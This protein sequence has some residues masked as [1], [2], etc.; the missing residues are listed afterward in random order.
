MVVETLGR[1][2]FN[3][4][5]LSF[6]QASLSSGRLT[7]SYNGNSFSSMLRQV[8]ALLARLRAG[9]GERKRVMLSIGGWQHLPTFEAIRSFGVQGFVRQ[10]SEE[11]IVPLGLDGIDL[12]LEPQTGGLDHW[13]RAHEEYGLTVVELTNEYKR[14]RPEHL[15]THAPISG[16]AAQIYTQPRPLPGLP[17]GLLAATR[18]GYGNNIDWLNVQMYEGGQVVGGDIAGYY[19]AALAA[20]LTKI[21]AQTGVAATLGF[22]TPLFQPDAK[23]PLAFCREVITSINRRCAD[24]D[25]GSVT[26]VA[27]WD[28]RQVAPSMREWSDG[29]NSVLHA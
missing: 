24:L 10:L 9:F 16:V 1:S 22:L 7:L 6:L 28:Y 11:V 13:I 15:V 5:V 12:D 17:K 19:R 2:R 26:G 25:A 14:V 23:Q 27:L 29:L 8:P 18:T 21:Q 20:P 4:L 3:V